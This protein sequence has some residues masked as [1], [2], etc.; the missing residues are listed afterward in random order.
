MSGALPV[1]ALALM[2]LSCHPEWG[3]RTTYRERPGQWGVTWKGRS[4]G[5]E[6]RFPSRFST[7]VP[8]MPTSFINIYNQLTMSQ[9]CSLTLFQNKGQVNES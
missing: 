5:G 3:P 8:D 4:L 7:E 2:G 1:P 9:I 6:L